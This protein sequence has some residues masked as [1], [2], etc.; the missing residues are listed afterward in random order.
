MQFKASDYKFLWQFKEFIDELNQSNS[1]NYKMEVLKKYA[2]N[3]CI[4]YFLNFL[5]NPYI[6]T[7]IS[8]KKLNKN[9]EL[10]AENLF[11]DNMKDRTLWIDYPEDSEIFEYVKNHNTGT[12]GNIWTIQHFRETHIKPE[13][14]DLFNKMITKNLPLGIDVLTINKCIPNLIPTF[15]VMLANKYFEK[16]E[17]V[18]GKEFVL[19]TKIDGSRIIAMK[20]NGKVSF[21]TRQGQ[22]YEGLVD[23]ENELLNSPEDNFVFDG[24]IVAIDTSKEDT[25]KNTMKLSRTKDLE[26]HGLKM[27]V[28][29]YMPIKNFKDQICGLPYQARRGVLTTLFGFN[30]FTYFEPWYKIGNSSK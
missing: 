27:L 22:K 6:V 25:Y 20:D 10:T 2:D 9:V 18:E 19:T 11:A 24:E 30:S 1:R 23:L 21:W 26:K 3:N 17:V 13:L 28:F 5:Y 4:K 15:N 14:H 12:D 16:P 29:D 7:G 8:D